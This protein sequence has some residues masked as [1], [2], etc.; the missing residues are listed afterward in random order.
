M[1]ASNITLDDVSG[2]DVTYNQVPTRA[3]GEVLRVDPSKDINQPRTMAIRH[4]TQGKGS[5]LADRHN[6][7]FSDTVKD[8]NGL[9]STTSVSL[10]IVVPRQGAITG[11]HVK[12][13]LANLVDLLASGAIASISDT[14]NM[15]ALL[16]GEA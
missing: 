2:D 14:S 8:V 11:I 3:L 10:T 5:L 1:L 4:S 16:R 13:L 7:T 6:V 12:D 9:A 15:D